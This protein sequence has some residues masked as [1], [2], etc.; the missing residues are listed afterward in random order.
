[1]KESTFYFIWNGTHDGLPRVRHESFQ[2]AK[3]EAERLAL[4]HPNVEFIVLQAVAS[5]VK[6]EIIWKEFS[7]ENEYVPY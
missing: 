3:V 7:D 4:K 6:T 2:A 5:A 1:M